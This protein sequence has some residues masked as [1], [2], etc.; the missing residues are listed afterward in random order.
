MAP[1]LVDALHLA[2]PCSGHIGLYRAYVGITEKKME[3]TILVALKR[4]VP[5][6]RYVPRSENA[7]RLPCNSC[8]LAGGYSL[9]AYTVTHEMASELMFQII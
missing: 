5:T 7:D 8:A 9:A 3:A 6:A 1:V 4:Y 2:H